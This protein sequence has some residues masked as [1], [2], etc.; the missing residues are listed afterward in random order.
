M[1][2]TDD[3]T[4][5]IENIG[6]IQNQQVSFDSGV[7]VLSGPNATN[8]TSLLRAIGGAL[9]GTAGVLRRGADSGAVTLTMNGTECRRRYRRSGDTVETIGNAYTDE[10]TLVDLFV[11][12]FE[13]N[14][15]RRAVRAGDDLTDLL[16]APVDM[17]E[18][19]AEIATARSKREHIDEQ[20]TE[21]ERERDQLPKLE[22]RRTSLKRE[23]DE[24]ETDLHEL[25]E[26][27]DSV[28]ANESNSDEAA[29]IQTALQ[30][31]QTQLEKTESEL[32]TQRTIR[33]EL[34]SELEEVREDQSQQESQ[35]DRLGE[36]ELEIERLQGRE[37]ELSATISQLSTVVKQNR[38][39]L[40]GDDTVVAELAATDNVLDELDPQRQSIEC[41]T[42]G[43]HVQRQDIAEQLGDVEQIVEQKRSEREQVRETLTER[44]SER[45]SI[46]QE[47][48][49]HETLAERETELEDELGRRAASIE[50]LI[51]EAERLR[52]ELSEQQSKLKAAKDDGGAEIDIYER[53]SELE[54]ERGQLERELQETEDEINGIEYQLGKSDDLETR[55]GELTERLQ[56]LRSRVET[57]ER[58]TVETFNEHMSSVLDA[59]EYDNIERIWLERRTG[60]D[61]TS[62]DLHVVREDET[63][64]VFEDSVHHLSE[65]EREVV[66]LVVAL[67]GYVTH[68][69]AET[70]PVL[71]FDSLEAIDGD[72]IADL[73]E[74]VSSHTEFL[75]LA[76]LEED[77]AK[78]SNAYDRLRAVEQLA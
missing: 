59:L 56:K 1:A 37:S 78:L 23:I 13:D 41:W 10:E 71:L 65:S 70:V 8:R 20:L 57:I 45:D 52:D 63:G 76:L 14:P 43:S 18:L 62:F 60:N 16:L 64:A 35:Q 36:I 66:G 46:Q 67:T 25:R 3:I 24:L 9:G 29:S 61:G 27:T 73:T 11:C 21:I 58:E 4:V 74:Y 5:R 42:C 15:I 75:L 2:D 55:R 44:R 17:E 30:E 69:V 53:I 47:I 7:T 48:E 22:Q 26:Q 38:E 12:L 34:K 33:D 19:E 40:S 51:A 50:D 31:T 39:V 54:Y 32:E 49:R 6:G 72:R 68:D 28:D 77:A